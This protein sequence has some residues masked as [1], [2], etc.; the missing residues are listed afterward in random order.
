[1]VSKD[2]LPEE[3]ERLLNCHTIDWTGRLLGASTLVTRAVPVIAKDSEE[4]FLIVN[5]AKQL[6]EALEPATKEEIFF[7]LAKFRLHY[8]NRKVSEAEYELLLTDYL[9]VLAP[10]PFDILEQAQLDYYA[11]Y[12]NSY[13]PRIGQLVALMNKRWNLRRLKFQRITKLL[14]V[15]QSN[16]NQG[17]SL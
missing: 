7:I 13:F 17:E 6:E 9:K 5:L 10:Y 4:Y 16:N 8:P 11:C 2:S 12:D 1:M 15:S 14:E 3:L